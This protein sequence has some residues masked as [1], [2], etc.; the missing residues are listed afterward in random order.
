MVRIP[1]ATTDT[2][3]AHRVSLGLVRRKNPLFSESA[4]LPSVLEAQPEDNDEFEGGD[5][6]GDGEGVSVAWHA[7][8]WG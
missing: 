3:G 1:M 4:G 6:D 8:G 5:G 7:R 2:Q